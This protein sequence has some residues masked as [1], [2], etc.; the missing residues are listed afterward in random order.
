V[1]LVIVALL[2]LLLLL[3]FVLVIRRLGAPGPVMPAR[4]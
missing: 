3:G 1:L 4:P 2:F